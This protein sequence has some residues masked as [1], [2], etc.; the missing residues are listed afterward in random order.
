MIQ[1]SRW[2]GQNSDSPKQHVGISVPEMYHT[3]P[4]C[5]INE[6]D[7]SLLFSSPHHSANLSS[8]FACVFQIPTEVSQP[9]EST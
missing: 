7:H 4:K 9:L 5:T 8:A 6:S 2:M 3:V 1:R